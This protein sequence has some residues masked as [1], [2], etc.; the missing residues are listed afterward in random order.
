[1]RPAVGEQL[2]I[3]IQTFDLILQYLHDIGGKVAPEK[4]LCFSTVPDFRTALR[5]HIWEPIK[6]TIPLVTSFRDLGARLNIAINANGP[7]SPKDLVTQEWPP[8]MDLHMG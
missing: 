8:A 4:S 1:M 5:V 6:A 7:P 3:I 2:C